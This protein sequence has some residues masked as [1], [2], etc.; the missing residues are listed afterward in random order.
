MFLRRRKLLTVSLVVVVQFFLFLGST[1]FTGV[2]ATQAGLAATILVA[3]LTLDAPL[4]FQGG[5]LQRRLAAT[6]KVSMLVLFG[7]AVFGSRWVTPALAYNALV[8]GVYGVKVVQT[9][10][11]GPGVKR[12][13][14]A[15]LANT[16]AG[17]VLS[18][19][20]K[21]AST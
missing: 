8:V 3:G 2:S 19:E 21:Y 14:T 4:L 18:K 11:L 16:F 15:P 10:R 9:Y 12:V 6:I 1:A 13:W 7:F 5:A 17:S 20:R